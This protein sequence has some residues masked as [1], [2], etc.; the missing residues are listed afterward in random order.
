MSAP[1]LI[2]D[3]FNLCFYLPVTPQGLSQ[4]AIKMH[5]L[6][7]RLQFTDNTMRD[8]TENEFNRATEMNGLYHEA[9]FSLAVTTNIDSSVPTMPAV[10][11]RHFA[12]YLRDGAIENI[13]NDFK[14]K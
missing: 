9:L 4:A 11:L 6:L 5:N 1:A 12:Q 13:R 8:T 2:K 10:S 14:S 3:R 7:R